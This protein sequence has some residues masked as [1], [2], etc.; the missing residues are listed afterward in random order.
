MKWSA[1]PHIVIP[2]QG[3]IQRLGLGIDTLPERKRVCRSV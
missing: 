2:A 3:G 1:H